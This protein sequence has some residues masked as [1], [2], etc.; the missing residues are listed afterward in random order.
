MTDPAGTRFAQKV[1]VGGATKV[2]IASHIMLWVVGGLVVTTGYFGTT[3]Q[4]V[5]TYATGRTGT[6]A[7]DVS[8]IVPCANTGGA[9]AYPHCNWQEPND[10]G[11]GTIVTYLE[12]Q[13]G[14]QPNS[15]TLD[16]VIAT[17]VTSSGRIIVNMDD[18]TLG[19]GTL[20]FTLSGAYILG[21]GDYIRAIATKNPAGGSGQLLIRYHSGYK[22]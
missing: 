18:K 11:S 10:N 7:V 4:T 21:D 3:S 6:G 9:L 8:V 20:L 1:Q 17:T 5:G 16:I 2:S 22:R 14:N 13:A 12:Y 19:S 15:T